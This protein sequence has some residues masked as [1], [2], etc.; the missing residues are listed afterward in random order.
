MINDFVHFS[1][2]HVCWPWGCGAW[3]SPG[4]SH[5][6][7]PGS[8]SPPLSADPR[9]PE[10]PASWMTPWLKFTCAH[11]HTHNGYVTVTWRRCEGIQTDQLQLTEQQLY[12]RGFA[13]FLIS[14]PSE[15]RRVG[16]LCEFML[17]WGVFLFVLFFVFVLK[18]DS[19]NL[20][21]FW[22]SLSVSRWKILE[23][24]YTKESNF[25]VLFCLEALPTL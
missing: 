12:L 19:N 3:A 15:R 25:F 21:V 8:W 5:G 16:R 9:G 11:T 4:S 22:P 20:N 13:A 24:C 6:R 2:V 7:S 23:W 18:I 1:Y 14:S 10:R 17:L